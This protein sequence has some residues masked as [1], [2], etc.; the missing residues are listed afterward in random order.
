MVSSGN[1]IYPHDPFEKPASRDPGSCSGRGAMESGNHKPARPR[2]AA[3]NTLL[4]SLGYLY[5]GMRRLA[6]LLRI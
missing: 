2:P 6:K 1:N 5:D 4:A 3:K